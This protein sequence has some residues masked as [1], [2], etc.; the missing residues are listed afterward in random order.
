MHVSYGVL[1]GICIQS[2]LYIAALYKAVTLTITITEQL[3][4][5]RP[6]YLLFS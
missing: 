3:P 2:N 6:L 5:K 4:K 1:L